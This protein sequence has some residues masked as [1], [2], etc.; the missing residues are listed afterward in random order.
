MNVYYDIAMIIDV[1]NICY[2][3]LWYGYDK[4]MQMNIKAMNVK[5]MWLWQY[6]GYENL[7]WMLV[8]I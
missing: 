5:M 7:L 4:N 6:Y 3:C 8:I 2:E 1:M